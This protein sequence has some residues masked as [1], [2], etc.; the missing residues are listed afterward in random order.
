[1][2]IHSWKLSMR[3]K[4]EY[5]DYNKIKP[6]KWT[7]CLK[8]KLLDCYNVLSSKTIYFEKGWQFDEY[9]EQSWMTK[10]AWLAWH[11]WITDGRIPLKDHTPETSYL[12]QRPPHA[13]LSKSKGSK[14]G[15]QTRQLQSTIVPADNLITE[16]KSLVESSKRLHYELNQSRNPLATE[17][18]ESYHFH[19]K[20]I[21]KTKKKLF[22]SVY[23]L[24]RF[25]IKC[26]QPLVHTTLLPL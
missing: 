1:M 23:F 21:K 26:I 13:K 10:E 2:C 12:T 18:S 24:F 16:V 19:Q 5:K 20:H 11:A 8:H 15:T 9:P 25:S 14:I 17:K 6:L 22:I 7:F 3:Q 4:V